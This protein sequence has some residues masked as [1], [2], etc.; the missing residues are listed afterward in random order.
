MVCSLPYLKHEFISGHV[1]PSMKNIQ[2][3]KPMDK[4]K[5]EF[6][7]LISKEVL[8]ANASRLAAQPWHSGVKRRGPPSQHQA[9][10]PKQRSIAT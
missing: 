3:E 6:C 4:L 10:D 8:Q 2:D 1:L 5:S 7:P 9:S